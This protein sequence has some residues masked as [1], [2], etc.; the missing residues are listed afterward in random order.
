MPKF[1]KIP[2][3]DEEFEGEVEASVVIDALIETLSDFKTRSKNI[4]KLN[5]ESSM[6]HMKLDIKLEEK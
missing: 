6:F 2:P 3:H 1:N 5:F 4:V